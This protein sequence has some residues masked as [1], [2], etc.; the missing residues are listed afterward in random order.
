MTAMRPLH[1]A[2]RVRDLSEARTFH[3]DLLECDEGRSSAKWVVSDLF[4]HRIVPHLSVPS[5]GAEEY[6]WPGGEK[7]PIHR[8]AAAPSPAEWRKPAAAA[9]RPGERARYLRGGQHGQ[10][11]LGFKAFTHEERIFAC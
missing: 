10:K 6:I 2:L 8:S 3:G 7:N 11:A 4:G 5:L 9:S 1:L